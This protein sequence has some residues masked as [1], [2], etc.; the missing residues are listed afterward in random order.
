MVYGDKGVG[1]SDLVDHMAMGRKGVIKISVSS[2]KSVNDWIVVI[3]EDVLGYPVQLGIYDLIEAMRKC[4]VIPT[5]IF[6][7]DLNSNTG[8]HNAYV[9]SIQILAKM[10]A[11]CCR[12]II[13]LPEATAVLDFD[14]EQDYADFICVDEMTAEEA[15]L[16]LR[17]LDFKGS[18]ADMQQ[19][20]A[21][22]GTRPTL[23]LSLVRSVPRKFSTVQLFIDD[24]IEHAKMELEIFRH[25]AILRALKDSPDGVSCMN[26][27]N[28]VSGDIRLGVPAQ[29]ADDMK[30][31]GAIF[32]HEG[33]GMYKLS[34]TAHKTALAKYVP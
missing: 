26:F 23:L 1:K 9:E 20:F 6:D 30:R 10:L 32:Y 19:V 4:K 14:R 11:K 5:I 8:Y 2:V 18:D 25:K 12:V 28:M 33:S 34:S 29:V 13:V 21:Q 24:L 3:A 22:I 17:S 7:V 15:G 27:A 16:M 31:S